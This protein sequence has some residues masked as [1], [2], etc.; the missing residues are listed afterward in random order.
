MI[1]KI[2][3]EEIL[4]AYKEIWDKKYLK[5]LVIS[6]F[7][8]AISMFFAYFSNIYAKEKASN[9]VTDILLDNLPVLHVGYI[10]VYG[11]ILLIIFVIALAFYKPKIA[12]F[13]AN[14]AAFFYIIRAIAVM[15]T[16][17]GPAP[18]RL[19]IDGF[20]MH[21]FFSGADLFFSGHTGMPFLLALIFWKDK[22]LRYLFLG[23]S[24]LMAIS[25]LLGH[26][27]YSIDVYSAYFITYT[28]YCLC[29]KFF[30][31]SLSYF[32]EAKI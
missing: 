11:A 6:L 2:W 18:D 4:P 25:V 8:L 28:I 3:R 10:F 21:S 32:N 5:T 16:H 1:K 17:I 30:Q 24:V 23:I 20:A 29:L 7:F 22:T 9:Y 14:C 12:P 27:H 13:V 26:L 19:N 31:K 15:L